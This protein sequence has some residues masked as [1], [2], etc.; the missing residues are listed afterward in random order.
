MQISC[1]LLIKFTTSEIQKYI[2]MY[3]VEAE[4]KCCYGYCPCSIGDEKGIEM[5]VWLSYL[6][7]LAYTFIVY[8]RLVNFCT[9][10]VFDTCADQSNCMYSYGSSVYCVRYVFCGQ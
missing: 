7:L 9:F 1:D 10:D 3:C 6:L 2:I 5:L 8:P 4:L